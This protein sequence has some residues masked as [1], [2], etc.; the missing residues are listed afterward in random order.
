MLNDNMLLCELVST[1]ARIYLLKI[2]KPHLS[3]LELQ[4]VLVKWCGVFLYLEMTLAHADGFEIV[5][6]IAGMAPV[7]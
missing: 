1:L 7:S 3:S 5:H 4:R 6:S 2:R